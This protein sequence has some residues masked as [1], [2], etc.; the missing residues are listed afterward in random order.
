MDLELKNCSALIT[1]ASKGI[2][3]AIAEGLARESVNLILVSRSSL[4]LEKVK[5]YLR[6]KYQISVRAI[7]LD[8]SDSQVIPNLLE[9]AK[10]IDIL[11]NN[12]G[13]IP[14]GDLETVTEEQWRKAWDLKVFG[15]INMTRAFF[16][17]MKDRKKNGV[18]INIT[19][20]SGIKLDANYIAGS[21]GNACLETFTRT[22]GAYSIDHGVRILAVS[23]GAVKTERLDALMKNKAKNELGDVSHWQ[24]YYSKLPLKRPATPEEIADLVVFLASNKA[25]Y[26]SGVVYH[27][28]G[29]HNARGSSFA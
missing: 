22:A 11:V 8:L 4:E 5:K 14:G 24:T 26:I 12:A 18:I 27:V 13:A 20:L 2:G 9:E 25:S 3:F 28:D 15:Y 1:G 29:G 6:D 7:S 23:P 17:M 21:S 16:K 19:G 10:D